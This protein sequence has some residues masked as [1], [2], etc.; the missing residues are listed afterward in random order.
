MSLLKYYIF[1]ILE[2]IFIINTLI[3]LIILSVLSIPLLVLL[4]VLFWAVNYFKKLKIQ[5]S[6]K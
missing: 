3:L 4:G 6:E 1:T 5:G 2:W